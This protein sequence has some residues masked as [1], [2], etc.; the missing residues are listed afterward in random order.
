[1]VQTISL[2]RAKSDTAED[3]RPFGADEMTNA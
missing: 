1:L 2:R 3:Y